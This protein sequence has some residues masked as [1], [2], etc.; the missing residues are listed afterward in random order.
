MTSQYTA[1]A[2]ATD[3]RADT[4]TAIARAAAGAYPSRATEMES[5]WA[6]PS[7]AC[8]AGLRCEIACP[9][10]RA[11]R[12]EVRP[13]T[14]DDG[15]GLSCVTAVLHLGALLPADVL[16]Q[17]LPP[18]A[19]SADDDVEEDVLRLWS[20]QSYRNG[21]YVF[22]AHAP[23]RLLAARPGA[24]LRVRRHEG[25]SPTVAAERVDGSPSWRE[26]ESGDL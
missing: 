8:G 21:M 10:V 14:R 20:V 9:G 16:V 13:S 7:D 11:A 18:P 15:S 24:R 5:G 19:A 4:R 12:I 1:S 23:D 26:T 3:S 22:E 6:R 2:G 25:G 17:L